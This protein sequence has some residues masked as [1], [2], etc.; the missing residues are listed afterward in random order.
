MSAMQTWDDQIFRP[1]SLKVRKL[2]LL[3]PQTLHTS[4]SLYHQYNKFGPINKLEVQFSKH[5]W[6]WAPKGFICVFVW[7]GVVVMGNPRVQGEHHQPMAQWEGNSLWKFTNTPQQVNIVKNI[8]SH[9][10][11]RDCLLTVFLINSPWPH[12]SGVCLQKHFAW[13]ACICPWHATIGWER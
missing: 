4:I 3:L 6:W 8:Y 10:F 12:N 5:S 13:S 9:P 11:Q 7:G 1:T 2:E